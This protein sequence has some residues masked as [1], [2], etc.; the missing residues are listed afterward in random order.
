MTQPSCEKLKARRRFWEAQAESV[1][2]MFESGLTASVI[3]RR[4]GTSVEVV[5]RY[6]RLAYRD[7]D[8]D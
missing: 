3:A 1:R 4:S 7:V 6:L 5:R 2:R 8:E